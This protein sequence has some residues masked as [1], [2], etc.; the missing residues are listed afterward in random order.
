MTSTFNQETLSDGEQ[1]YAALQ[2]DDDETLIY[3][4]EQPNAWIQSDLTVEPRE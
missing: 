4:R 1:R 2:T 3:D